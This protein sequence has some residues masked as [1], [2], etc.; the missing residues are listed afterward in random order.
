M[1]NS[2]SNRTPFSVSFKFLTLGLLMFIVGSKQNVDANPI[3]VSFQVFYDEL[4]PYGDWIE[5]PNYGF[6]WAPY[7]DQSFQPYRTNGHWVMSTYGN[8][9][10]SQYDWGW[11]PFHY[12]RWFFSD[13]YG[14][15]WIPGYDWGPAWVNWR[16]GRGYY[17]WMPLGPQ[18]YFYS[19]AGYYNHSHWVFVPRRRL[20][21]R[22]INRYYMHGRNVNVIYN[23]TTIIN[24]TFVHNNNRYISGPSRSELQQVTRG[25]VPVFEVRQGRRPGRTSLGRNSINVYRPQVSTRSS[26]RNGASVRPNKYVNAKEYSKTRAASARPSNS[27]SSTVVSPRSSNVRSE[28][29]RN[30]NTPSTRSARSAVNANTERNNTPQRSVSPSTNSRSNSNIGNTNSRSR[31]SNASPNS[32]VIQR[33]PTT[34][35]SRNEQRTVTPNYQ[36][37]RMAT[38]VPSQRNSGVNTQKRETRQS[39]PTQR[40]VIKSTPSRS[41][42]NTRKVTPTTRSTNR[43][44]SAP[45]RSNSRVNSSSSRTQTRSTPRSTTRSSGNTSTTRS[46]RSSR[47]N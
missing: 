38:P 12:G 3:S 17:G 8:T 14:W 4:S 29:L 5:D 10:V 34:A 32:G 7:V 33:R 30:S 43:V 47:G 35:P 26:S 9:W 37:N 28:A 1:K 22:R 39:T 42:A 23:Q 19:T 31:N 40:K 24:N 16:S 27:R 13:F 21:S 6:I 18:T 20:L 15:A 46:T 44:K 2:K 36:Q 41:N 45:Q 11:A 25:N